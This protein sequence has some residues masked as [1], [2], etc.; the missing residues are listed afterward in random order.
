MHRPNPISL[1][2]PICECP[3][4]DDS[5]ISYESLSEHEGIG[6]IVEAH[7]HSNTYGK[8]LIDSVPEQR[9]ESRQRFEFAK[10]N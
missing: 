4:G 9:T 3:Q 7:I 5:I 2:E 10:N 8:S 1:S 6:Y